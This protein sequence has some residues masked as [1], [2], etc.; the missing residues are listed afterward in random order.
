VI[1]LIR[2]L[3]EHLKA[4]AFQAKI[5]TSAFIPINAAEVVDAVEKGLII[6]ASL[7]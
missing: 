5:D 7:L 2:I 1:A 4:P 6:R 3:D